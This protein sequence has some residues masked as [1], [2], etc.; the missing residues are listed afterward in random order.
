MRRLAL[1]AALAASPALAQSPRE[2]MFPSDGTCYLR[3]YDKGHMAAHP[4][5]RVREIAIGPLSGSFG[6]D[7][8]ILAVNVTL[9]DSPEIFTGAAYCENSADTL[10][11]HLEGDAGWFTLHPR[12]GGKILLEVSRDG[13]G[14]EGSDFIELSGNSGDDREF[15]L[16]PVPAD[17]CP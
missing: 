13:I 4:A 8:L 14:F 12:P 6:G 3:H 1:L 17:S 7:E 15:L 16:P 11:C 5:Q 2:A 10:G 9:R